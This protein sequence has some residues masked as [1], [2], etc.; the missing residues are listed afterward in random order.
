MAGV[1]RGE[2]KWH[3]PDGNFW[4]KR[5]MIAVS[6]DYRL[7]D[8]DQVKVPLECVKDAKSAIRYLRANAKK[9][10]IDPSRVVAKGDSG[11]RPVSRRHCHSDRSQ[12][13]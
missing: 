5:G 2:T 3:W 8:R 6:V 10:K 9:L 11:W 12:D 13:Q 4:A 7:R 1:G